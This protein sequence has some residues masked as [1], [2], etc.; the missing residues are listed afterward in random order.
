MAVDH[1]ENFPVASLLLPR[2]LRGAVTDIYRYARTADDIA[3][4][5][6]LT[7]QERLDRLAG[8]RRELESIARDGAKATFDPALVSVF[9]PLAETIEQHHLPLQ[10]FHELLSAF[11]QDVTVQRYEYDADLLDYCS[12]SA[13]PVGHLMLHLYGAVNDDNIQLANS[14]CT[15]LQLTN[16]W[17]DVAIDWQKSRLYLPLTSMR[18]H[19]VTE[20]QIA[21]GICNDA[22]RSLMRE[23]VMQA[24]QFL[25]QGQS[26]GRKLP[27]RIGLELR[28]VVQGGLRILQRLE[29]L[30]YDVFRARPTL[31][32]QDWPLLFW[33]SV[34]AR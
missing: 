26:L 17:Q 18:R 4:E 14:I 8:Y 22:W 12:R 6:P 30:N 27:G 29:Q 2:H 34:R 24:R 25:L 9:L 10:P 28:M 32:F 31:G 7:P 33:R 19:G 16:F 11:E 13:N 21:A 20:E 5:G 1:Y 23:R 15:G 3:D